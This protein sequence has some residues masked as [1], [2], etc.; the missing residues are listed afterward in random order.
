MDI[1]SHEPADLSA[2]QAA[3]SKTREAQALLEKDDV[4]AAI[5]AYAEALEIRYVAC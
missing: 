1:V 2:D 4:E 5:E 3:D